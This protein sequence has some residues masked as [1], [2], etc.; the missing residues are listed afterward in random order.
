MPST[1]LFFPKRLQGTAL[2]DPGGRRQFR[3][4]RRP[5]RDALDHRLRLA[6]S[7]L[8]GS[9]TFTGEASRRP[10]WLQNAAAIYI[11]FILVFGIA[12][13]LM[14][15]SVPVRA[16]FREQLDIFARSTASS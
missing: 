16:N 4:Q 7:L 10:I 12:A 3:R 2:A 5:V 13:W 9:Q 15:R 1:S 6:G 11:P 8:G 14:L